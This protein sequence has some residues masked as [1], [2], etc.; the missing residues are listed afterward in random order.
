MGLDIDQL[1][2]RLNKIREISIWAINNGYGT[3]VVA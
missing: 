1:E 2:E 3:I